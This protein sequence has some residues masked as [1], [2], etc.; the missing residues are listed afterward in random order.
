[1]EILLKKANI[2]KNKLK[3]YINRAVAFEL[4]KLSEP[5]YY[6]P[7][8][9]DFNELLYLIGLTSSDLNYFAKRYHVKR[10]TA[11][12]IL[13]D[14]GVNLILFILHYFL[15]Q[16][17]YQS[18]MTTMI[19]L[20]IKFYSSRLS[21][22][23]KYCNPEIFKMTLDNISKTN[24]ISR[25][26]TIPNFLY[27]IAKAMDRIWK[28][29]I[30]VFDNPE[31]IS[32]FVYDCRSRIAQTMRSFAELY[33]KYSD[34]G[35]T[36]YSSGE[37][38]NLDG[39]TQDVESL[40]KGQRIIEDIVS[41]ITIYKDIDKKA[42]DEAKKLSR[43]NSHIAEY[44]VKSLCNTKYT[45]DLKIIYELYIKDLKNIN[46][47]CGKEFL[48][49]TKSL[50]NLKRTNQLIYYKKQI[51]KLTEVILINSEYENSYNKLTNQ[52]KFL[53]QSFTSLYLSI[54][55]RNKIC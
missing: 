25:E 32:K 37:E 7:W 20:C 52:T 36:G 30:E 35:I 23:F 12:Y 24:L 34:A 44:I 42:Y 29:D 15:L 19:L 41:K 10:V 6:P 26:K 45:N 54:Y 21:I 38:K 47:L 22:H 46:Q 13:N 2:D 33:Y 9:K 17:D 55:F 11:D 18:F 31:N 27:H 4:T 3:N 48:N 51:T 16:K 50:M 14:T 49:Y 8:K 1:M 53:I 43:I 5:C 39:E 40:K 28:K